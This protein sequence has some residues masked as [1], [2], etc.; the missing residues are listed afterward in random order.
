M[1]DDDGAVRVLRDLLAHRA[2]QQP[3]EPTSAPG[4]DY[5]ECRI[6]LWAQQA[7]LQQESQNWSGVSFAPGQSLSRSRVDAS[8]PVAT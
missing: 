6:A 4:A 2:E 7:R 3:G 8:L 1:H 5:D